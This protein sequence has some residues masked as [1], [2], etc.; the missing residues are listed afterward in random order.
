MHMFLGSFLI[1]DEEAAK[2]CDHIKHARRSRRHNFNTSELRG[3]VIK[4]TKDSGTPDDEDI[5]TRSHKGVILS[6]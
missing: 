1:G 2:H 4:L 3:T 6:L 5:P